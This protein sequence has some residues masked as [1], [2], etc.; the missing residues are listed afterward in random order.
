MKSDKK[1][2]KKGF[3]KEIFKK[4]VRMC[5]GTNL[6]VPVQIFDAIVQPNS[7]NSDTLTCFV[8]SIDSTIN[9]LEVRYMLCIDDGELD[10]PEDGSLVTIAKTAFT[11]PYIVKSTSLKSKV[12][13]IGSQS[14]SN[15][16]VVQDFEFYSKSGVE[17]SF[18][19]FIKDIDPEDPTKG[20][21]KKIN[22]LENLLN[23]LITKYNLHV[24]TGGTISGSTGIPTVVE[25]N[26]IYPI[27]P[28]QRTDI[29]N[30]NIIHGLKNLPT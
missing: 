4:A 7:Q 23:D 14:Y 27:T 18:G 29:E 16:G 1:G 11:D 17:G 24:H 6:Q 3:D 21:L 2:S 19:G 15:D 20:L 8:D 9:N 5:A 25:T 13:T 26:P 30:P 10:V 28:T 12:I 22:N